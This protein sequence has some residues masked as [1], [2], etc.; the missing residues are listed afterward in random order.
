L[1]FYAVFNFWPVLQAIKLS[2]FDWDGIG[3][4]T[5]VGLENYGA[6]FSEPE[7]ISALFHAFFLIIFFT[8]IPVTLGL[9]TASLMRQIENKVFGVVARTVLFLPQ[10]IPGA[11]AAVAW[12]WMYSDKGLV[13]QILSLLGLG[14]VTRPWLADFDWALSAVGFIGTWL[15]TGFC[16]LLLM[17]GIGKIDISL[18]EAAGLDGAGPLA[19]FWGVTFPGLRREIG[20]CVTLTIIQA[21]ASFDVVYL[22]T[23]GGPGYSTLVPGVFVYRQAFVSSRIGV[24]TAMGVVL[25]IVVIAVIIPLQRFFREE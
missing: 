24:A 17:A 2:F 19:K 12:T 9:I 21:L 15:S 4:Q 16:T 5:F 10:I 3:P 18:Y 1:L 23:Q 14:G 20:V 6:V 8:L 22:A 13:N 25:S 11:A 7:G